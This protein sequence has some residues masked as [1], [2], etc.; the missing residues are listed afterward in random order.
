MAPSVIIITLSHT[1]R[2][3]HISYMNE[4]SC[5]LNAVMWSKL[6]IYGQGV[7]EVR[8]EFC[9]IKCFVILIW[10]ETSAWALH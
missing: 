6:I 3:K 9:R 1:R 7:V 2:N 5:R 4:A 10:Y 8:K